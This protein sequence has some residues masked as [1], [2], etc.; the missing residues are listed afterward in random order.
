MSL[1]KEQSEFVAILTRG[2]PNLKP[3]QVSL[4]AAKFTRLSVRHGRLQEAQC[5]G[6]WPADNGERALNT[7]PRCGIGW[8]VGQV[9]KAGCPDCRCEDQVNALAQTH[10]LEAVFQGD[11]RGCT[12]KLRIPNAHGKDFGGEGLVCVPQ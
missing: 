7:C 5:T 1:R 10:G 11:P 4:L 12:V 2:M 9:K 8:A 3:R 6:D